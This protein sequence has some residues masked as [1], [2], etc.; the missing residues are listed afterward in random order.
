M[1]LMEAPPE[2]L[3][4]ILAPAGS[5][6]FTVADLDRMPHDGRRYELLDGVLVVSP[7]PSFGHQSMTL[8]LWRQLRDTAPPDL[9][10]MCGPY[11][12]RITEN[13]SF[14]PDVLVAPRGDYRQRA[15]Y[16]PPLLVVEVISPGSKTYDR[17]VKFDFYQESGVPS[18]WILDPK[19]ATLTAYE[20]RDGAYAEVAHVSGAEE[21]RAERPFPV[22][23]V[24]ATL[25]EE[26]GGG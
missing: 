20:L 1:T 25:V 9:Y 26:P 19:A 21:F 5:G 17:R 6:P 2:A 12:W 18:Y 10:V 16:V 7:S 23:I 8:L 14:E 11:D 13:R 3:W 24:P 22:T 15:I 4:S